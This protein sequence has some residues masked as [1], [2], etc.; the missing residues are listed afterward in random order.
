[1]REHLSRRFERTLAGDEKFA[2]LPGLCWLWTAAGDSSM[3]SLEGFGRIRTVIYSRN[4]SC[5]KKRGNDC[6]PTGRSPSFFRGASPALQILQRIRD[7]AHRFAITYHRSVRAK[8]SLYSRL[9]EIEG[10]GDKR[11]RVLYEKFVTIDAVSAA[12]IDELRAVPGMNIRA[13]QAVIIFSIP[14]NPQVRLRRPNWECGS[15]GT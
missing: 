11:K 9:D 5:R 10:I 15:I 12:E 2:E 8:N 7:E 1:M 6:S 3:L 4:R 13:A 14:T